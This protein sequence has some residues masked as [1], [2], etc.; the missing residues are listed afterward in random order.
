[1]GQVQGAEITAES[2]IRKPHRIRLNGA[3]CTYTKELLVSMSAND[4]QLLNLI[5][6]A[7]I[8]IEAGS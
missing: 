3:K 2:V 8:R 5:D 1:V 7:L 4:R 6:E